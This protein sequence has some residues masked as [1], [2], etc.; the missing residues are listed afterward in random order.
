M[1][2]TQQSSDT[3]LTSLVR[4]RLWHS[5]SPTTAAAAGLT[6]GEL[7]QIIAHAFVP[8]D[9]QVKALAAHLN[10]STVEPKS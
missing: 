3:E 5:L 10:I 4:K 6:V 9:A 7:Q 1:T 8:T 2:T